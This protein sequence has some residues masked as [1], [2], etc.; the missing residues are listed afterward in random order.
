MG[1]V[2]TA[3]KKEQNID[4]VLEEIRNSKASEREKG[5]TFERLMLAYFRNDPLQNRLYDSVE[6]FGD[7]AGKRGWSKR[8]L[9]I[10]LVAKLR[11]SN[12]CVAIQCKCYS[13][14]RVLSA[15]DI[16]GFLA[17]SS[18]RPFVH[19]VFV[20]TTLGSWSPNIESILRDQDRELSRINL[21]QL[22]ESRFPWHD[23]CLS[24]ST[25]LRSRK[26]L[27]LRQ[28][29]AFDFV[30]KGLADKKR[31][32]LLMACGTG[33]T[34]TSLR[35]AE[36][37]AGAGGRVLLFSPS[38][39]LLSQTVMHW[40][41]D[42]VLPLQSFAVCSDV[43]IGRRLAQNPE[44][45]S[46]D[47]PRSDLVIPAT[48]DSS[49]LLARAQRV[50]PGD[51]QVIFATYHSLSVIE[52]AQRAGLPKFD[53]VICDEAHRTTG[54]T[55][56]DEEESSFVK[57]HSDEHI[58]AR[59]RLYMTATQR[60]YRDRVKEEAD[61]TSAVVC[62]MDDE[63]TYGPL[64]YRLSFSQAV[65]DKM[66]TDFK[67]LVLAIEDN[68]IS[69]QD[70]LHLGLGDNEVLLDDTTKMIGCYKALAGEKIGKERHTTKPMHRGLAFLNTIESSKNFADKFRQAIDNY[71]Q[72]SSAR[73]KP[74]SF[75]VSVRHIDGRHKAKERDSALEW[76]RGREEGDGECRLLSNVRCLSE[77]VD[78][79]SL[80]AVIFLHPRKS[81]T[82]IIQA[83]GRV[84]RAHKGKEIG[85]VLLPIVMPPNKDPNKALDDN[86]R[87]RHVWQTLNALR[88]HDE[89]FDR[90]INQMGLGQPGSRIEILPIRAEIETVETLPSHCPR[91][92]EP[93]DIG[94]A[95][96]GE[97]SSNEYE[98]PLPAEE[99]LDE[100]SEE[101]ARG[102]PGKNS[103]KMWHQPL[104]G[105][106]GRQYRE[107]HESPY[108]ASGKLPNQARYC[109]PQGFR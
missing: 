82:D 18:K 6:M 8:D 85:Y 53:L 33:K 94:G 87:Y 102:N 68:L 104:L 86:K 46:V 4:S 71:Y 15:N 84:M 10:D 89:S 96:T 21:T 43:Q 51:M 1:F 97:L 3:E 9:G 75:D 13:P 69:K 19:R 7:W 41:Q 109:Q 98:P 65:K 24:G 100:Y 59:K 12:D 34:L 38:L 40:S 90:E 61:Q 17:S 77:G 57:V 64:F 36:E 107:G 35:I 26:D 66:L 88:S 5:E 99:F 39:A 29:E 50:G 92:G 105:H 106:M 81:R 55:L 31:G 23:Y 63:D 56:A 30:C 108:F 93:I 48:T 37:I 47:I 42:S 58:R 25:K 103:R 49:R 52:D 95:H 60:I 22:R 74:V 44:D 76:L 27:W 79:P 91:K 62:S 80:D 70:Q 20:D 73:R 32:H 14:E 28:R 11:D 16:T 78:V 67:V 54:V 2:S 72:F 101:L 83:V 45:D